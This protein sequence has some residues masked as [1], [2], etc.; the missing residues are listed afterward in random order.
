[1]KYLISLTLAVALLLSIS[2]QSQAQNC[3]SAAS[4]VADIWSK[5]HDVAIQGGCIAADAAGYVNYDACFNTVTKIN[6]LTGKLVTFWNSKVNNSWATIGPRKLDL[7]QW[8]TGNIVGTTGRKFV[9]FPVLNA[10]SITVTIE[11]TGGKGKTS[12]TVCKINA[13]GIKT[14]IGTQWFNDDQAA[15]NKSN[16]INTFTI[17]GAKNQIITIHL[18]GKS[19][20]NSFNYKLKAN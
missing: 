20:G 4:V 3:N 8:H 12:A 15:K 9:S 10:N 14:N 5:V 16:E 7:N 18:D 11:E 2:N 17:N 1:M 13:A 19:V 6:D